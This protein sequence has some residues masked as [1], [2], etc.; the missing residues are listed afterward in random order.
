MWML[1]SPAKNLNEGPASREVPATLPGMLGDTAELLDVTKQK[2]SPQLQKLM[3]ISEKLGDLNYGRFQEMELPPAED[4]A[5]QAALLFAG[6]TYTGLDAASL[7]ADDLEWAQEHLAILS[8]L[9]GILRP[10]DLV[11]PYRLEMGTK[12]ETKRG[13]DL[14][15]FWGHR[16]ADTLREWM[17]DDDVIVNLASKEYFK[18]LPKKALKGK[19][20]VTPKFKDRW[21][22]KIRMISFYAKQARGAMARWAIQNRVTDVEQLKDAEVMGY[23]FMPEKS[24]KTTWVYERDKPDPKG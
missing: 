14:Y 15:D 3:N 11:Q 19:T 21:D 2:S 6:D 22:G 1:L 12:L 9:Y 13:S 24:T 16:I 5:R 10:L 8:G 23:T 20:I 7:S 17:G 18:A 4:T